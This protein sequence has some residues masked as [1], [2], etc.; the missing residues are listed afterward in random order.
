MSMRDGDRHR[1]KKPAI[2]WLAKLA[3]LGGEISD[4]E[5]IQENPIALGQSHW[6]DPK[7]DGGLTCM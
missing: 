4:T 5:T 3:V 7:N 1:S 6:A 2:S